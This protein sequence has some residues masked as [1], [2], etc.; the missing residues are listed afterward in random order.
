MRH[1]ICVMDKKIYVFNGYCYNLELDDYGLDRD[2]VELVRNHE[3]LDL[4]ETNPEW[5]LCG[6]GINERFCRVLCVVPYKRQ[7]CLLGGSPKT[8]YIYDPRKDKLKPVYHP[9]YH[10]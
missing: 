1:K 8:L 4:D 5:R 10:E 3:V 7:M 6:D 2:L 9:D